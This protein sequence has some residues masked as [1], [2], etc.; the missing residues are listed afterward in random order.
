MNSIQ[1]LQDRLSS[2]AAAVASLLS[3][4]KVR[5]A[6]GEACTGGYVSSHLARI[7]A[8]QSVCGSIVLNSESTLENWMGIPA[9]V[10]KVAGPVSGLVAK[11]L[12]TDLLERTP[13][14]WLAIA[15]TGYLGPRAPKGRMGNVF[16]GV[17]ARDIK[18]A[19]AQQFWLLPGATQSTK[20]AAQSTSD[21]IERRLLFASHLTL[22]MV[23][24]L[25]ETTK[26]FRSRPRR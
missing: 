9:N 2:E 1:Q 12:A 7:G 21:L 13:D 20:K 4:K 3:R 15:I 5:I 18:E 14:A 10:L 19:W 22:F 16:L 24:S 26:Y 17:A 23:R 11:R 8:H 25:L 6:L